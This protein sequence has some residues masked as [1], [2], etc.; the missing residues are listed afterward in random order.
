MAYQKIH[1]RIVNSLRFFRRG[2]SSLISILLVMLS[3]A[4]HAQ[5]TL[6]L[7]SNQAIPQ[8]HGAKKIHASS[9]GEVPSGI[10]FNKD[11]VKTTDFI[12]NMAQQLGIGNE[13]TLHNVKTNTDEIGMTHHRFQQKYKGIPVEGMEYRVHV[14]SGYVVSANGKLVRQIKVDVKPTITEEQAFQIAKGK[15]K[16]LNAKYKPGQLLITAKD[17]NFQSDSLLLAYQ[18]DIEVSLIEKWRVSID[19][20][21]GEIINK[22]SLVHACSPPN[23]EPYATGTG[24]TNYN[25]VKEIKTEFVDSTYR[26]RGMTDY[27]ISIETYDL[28]GTY[29]ETQTD[30]TD[31]DNDFIDENAKAGVSV[32]W[33]VEQ[34]LKY[35]TEKHGRYSI[36]GYGEPVY[37]YVH[38]GNEVANAYGSHSYPTQLFFGDGLNNSSPWVGLDIIGH[39]IS[40]MLIYRVS[41]LYNVGEMGSLTESF[42][43]I[44]GNAI[45]QYSEGTNSNWTIGE[46]VK[47]G[48]LRDLSDPNNTGQPDTYHGQLW[49]NNENSDL[50]HINSG[51]QNYWFYLLCH[52]GSGVN[53]H[54]Q[55]YSV[56]SIGR[57]KAMAI[58]YENLTNYIGFNSQFRDCRIASLFATANL[59]GSESLTYKAVVKAWEAVGVSDNLKPIIWDVKAANVTAGSVLL[60]AKLPNNFPISSY[61]FEY[62][63]TPS[64]G[65][66]ASV[67]AFTSGYSY[68]MPQAFIMGLDT[69]TH[70]YFRFVATNNNGTSEGSG[71]FITGHEVQPKLNSIYHWSV[72][73][74]SANIGSFFT[75]NGFPT[76]FFIE[77]GTNP[78]FGNVTPTNT[79]Y[80]YYYS[81]NSYVNTNLS[82]LEPY[83]TYYYRAIA[84]NEYGSDTTAT[85]T[86]FT[87]AKPIIISL[88]AIKAEVGTEIKI[89]GYYFNAEPSE[90]IVHFG[91]TR[92][93]VLSST[94]E[95]LIVQVPVGASI[96]S[97]SY[98]NKGSGL[99]TVSRQEFVPIVNIDFRPEN[100]ELKCTI[101]GGFEPL[102]SYIHDLDGDL[103][104][105]IINL[106]SGGFSILRNIHTGG[107][108]LNSSFLNTDYTISPETISLDI[109]EMNGDGR[110]DIIVNS[111][112]GFH[113]YPNMSI[114]GQILFDDPLYV[115]LINAT[116]QIACGDF[117]SD[118]RIDIAVEFV[119][120]SISVFKNKNRDTLLSSNFSARS[121]NYFESRGQALTSAFLYGDGRNDLIIG[122]KD[123]ARFIVLENYTYSEDVYYFGAIPVK[124]PI[125]GTGPSNFLVYDL[126]QDGFKEIITTPSGKDGNLAIFQTNNIDPFVPL[127]GLLPEGT[128]KRFVGIADMNGDG[129]A[130]LVVGTS[131]GKFSI[132]INSTPPPS[133]LDSTSFHVLADYGME[134]TQTGRGLAVNDLNGDGK[135]DLV[136]ISGDGSSIE[137]WENTAPQ[138]PP[139][140]IPT[141]ISID[142][143]T[144]LNV[145]VSWQAS[146]QATA[147]QLEYS[148]ANAVNWNPV[149]V[150]DTIHSIFYLNP[151]R[152]YLARIK[153]ICGNFQSGYDSI[154]FTTP[155]PVPSYI[156]VYA[157]KTE[158]SVYWYDQYYI[159]NYKIEYR[160]AGQDW[161]SQN[162]GYLYGLIPGKEYEIRIQTICTTGESEFLYGGFTTEC[163]LTP[164]L[165][166]SSVTPASARVELSQINESAKYF[167]EY[168]RNGIDWIEV[169]SSMELSDLQ[170][171]T[172]YFVR[173]ITDCVN[174]DSVT[175]SF[176]TVCP[177][178]T[179][180]QVNNITPTTATLSWQDDFNIG[181]YSIEYTE[182]GV[183]NW[184]P[185]ETASTF[186][187]IE[188]LAQE[189]TYKARVHSI[190]PDRIS[191]REPIF[192]TTTKVPEEIILTE[193]TIFP[194][195]SEGEL[196]I[197]PATSSIGKKAVI[198]DMKGKVMQEGV[199]EEINLIDV[200]SYSAGLFL[201]LIEGE[202]PMKFSRK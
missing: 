89:H 167:V 148:E 180:F 127:G 185:F 101:D 181:H 77:Y 73:A 155:C 93:P 39:E 109:A 178:P 121:T 146:T 53:D 58:V 162:G 41:G 8:I 149:F 20:H 11:A 36:Q 47:E 56:D 22:I 139:C 28:H 126:N 2:N 114:P 137:I 38:Y 44:F 141:E 107:S 49:S 81:L 1:S 195:P 163:P 182:L 104:P 31:P 21:K 76:S 186:H 144:L 17:F 153:S 50:S 14:K 174:P 113:I 95:I 129:I 138:G 166:V 105:D 191:N 134:G 123:S 32:H 110:K 152:Q 198:M 170:M 62:G 156:Q 7:P 112:N 98:T 151:G 128:D 188:G 79:H 23:P 133:S 94:E 116:R 57:E 172:T 106:H 91:A 132:L 51:V 10:E 117:D 35:F 68:S 54:G 65:I 12:S 108:L 72:N 5:Q 164:S 184:A 122:I 61:Y 85:Y 90:N 6:S 64:Y 16:A 74:H 55:A 175:V 59:Y 24:L 78:E 4:L 92:A 46:S 67:N 9:V 26:L 84:F 171:G 130:D 136:N 177:P 193:T 165:F 70:Y 158:A 192:F 145:F 119:G 45:E 190:C 179:S 147:Y 34:S 88:D 161:I 111:Q 66:Y 99:S 97:I 168:S 187:T 200:S 199:L 86:F 75:T 80:P 40:H 159:G 160:L 189:T 196:T 60:Q 143:M 154:F 100:L 202:K 48:G 169:N 135:T 87:A 140:S 13:S 201:L 71:E 173:A 63:T 131:P 15:L 69:S 118:G 124:N 82:N 115:N 96:G 42:S 29:G 150:D 25:G 83:K 176:R 3:F 43:D 33:G 102:R 183:I 157:G 125:L 37:S 52:G 197:K 103:K 30:I 27:G 18:F 142:S 194:N 120:D 19:A